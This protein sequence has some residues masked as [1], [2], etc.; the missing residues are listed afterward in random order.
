MTD[1][2]TLYYD[3]LHGM[4]RLFRNTKFHSSTLKNILLTLNDTKLIFHRDFLFLLKDILKQKVTYLSLYKNSI[5]LVMWYLLI[6]RS[7]HLYATLNRP[8]LWNNVGTLLVTMW[9]VHY[10]VLSILN[11]YRTEINHKLC[12]NLSWPMT[13]LKTD[14]K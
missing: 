1:V 9:A 13:V 2:C 11:N 12:N 5:A 7:T 4:C 8:Y 3:R 14:S 10:A 6:T